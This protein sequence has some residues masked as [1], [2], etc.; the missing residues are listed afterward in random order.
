[1]VSWWPGD[2]DANDIVGSNNGTL[3]GGAT[4]APGEVREAFSFNGADAYV[5]IPHNDNLNPTGPFS[6][7]AWV[8]ANPNQS[9]PQV[10]IVDKSHGFT[11]STGWL[12][13]TNADGTA[14]FEYGLGGGG[15]TNFV[16]A[17]TQT[18]ILDAQWYHLAGVW[19]GTEVQIY[20]NGVLQN[21]TSSSALPAN[22][23]R[24][25]H[26]GMAWGG[27]TPTRFFRGLIDEVEYFNRALSQ[28]E[29]QAIFN[30]GSAGKCKTTTELETSEFSQCANISGAS[31]TPTAT[32]TFTPTA[33]PTPTHS[34]T[35]T[36]TA[37]HTPTAT[38][39]ATV[40]ATATVTPTA[41]PTPTAL[42]CVLGQGFW[43]NHPAQWPVTQL[44]LGKVT[45]N[46]QQLL[47]ILNQ[48]VRGNGLISLAYQEIAA[49]L[50]IANGAGA[51]CVQQTLTTADALIGGLVIPPVG[52]GFLPPTPLERPL[53]QYNE[54][55]SCIPS[56]ET[57]PQPTPV[58]S[59]RPRPTPAPRS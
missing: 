37:T 59:P 5:D 14:C 9:F 58:V 7:D 56:C 47:S 11:D 6:V 32:P 27:G 43:K 51:S 46:Q 8:N 19:T 35:A 54:G 44:Q 15:N 13:Q 41:T 39:T 29:I 12:L 22:N 25:V 1:M 28:S 57:P 34:P 10:L 50:N 26:M 38:P 20:K 36:P 23:N 55:R 45:Y 4:F 40:T 53:D 30:A 24:D 16:G 52:N 2:D 3:Q 49:K 48:P 31:P 33:T 17:C 42:G 18:S 21:T